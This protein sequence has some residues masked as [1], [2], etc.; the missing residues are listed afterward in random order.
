MGSLILLDPKES[1]CLVCLW[2]FG[3]MASRTGGRYPTAPWRGVLLACTDRPMM[4]AL[5]ERDHPSMMICASLRDRNVS[6]L[7]RSPRT[8]SRSSA[9]R[10]RLSASDSGLQHPPPRSGAELPWRRSAESRR[11]PADWSPW[12]MTASRAA[13]MVS[14]CLDHRG[15]CLVCVSSVE[16]SLRRTLAMATHNYPGS[17]D[18]I[19]PTARTFWH[20]V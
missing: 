9:N 18:E 8:L 2:S 14:A 6:P 5:A 1:W 20:T 16:T 17:A 10:L 12:S 15:L 11:M 3:K 19:T 7:R 13:R 4:G